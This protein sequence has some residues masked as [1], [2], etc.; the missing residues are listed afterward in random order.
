MIKKESEYAQHLSGLANELNIKNSRLKS[1]EAKENIP[2]QIKNEE[3]I[4]FKSG[5]KRIRSA[6]METTNENLNERL[7][8]LQFKFQKLEEFT[9]QKNVDEFCKKFKSNAQKVFSA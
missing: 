1:L 8:N 4:G 3:D 2:K 5:M 9:E 7:K 6:Q